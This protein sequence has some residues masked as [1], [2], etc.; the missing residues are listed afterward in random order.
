MSSPL[1]ANDLPSFKDR[2]VSV[3]VVN[4]NGMR[5]LENC[6]DS[7][8]SAFTRYSLELIVVDNASSD[9]SQA[10]LRARTDIVYV[11]SK[12]NSGFTGGNNLGANYAKGDVLLFINNDTQVQ[13]SL[14]EVIDLLADSHTGIS[15][16]RLL[17]GD[18]RQQF[19]FGYEHTPIRIFCS[20]LGLEKLY[21]LPTIFRKLET[22]PDAYLCSQNY[23]N[24]VSGACFAI[25]RVDWNAVNGFD[26]S[27]F[28]YCEDV[29]LCKR[30][31]DLGL[32]IA[33]TPASTVVHYEGSGKAWI[34][35][36]ALQR[37]VK[38]YQLFTL[39]HYGYTTAM[40][41]SLALAFVFATRALAFGI[42][43]FIRAD[44]KQLNKEKA[45]GFWRAGVQLV[46]SLTPSTIKSARP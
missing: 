5:F 8:K 34:G 24:W 38:S 29:D 36:T 27:Y 32:T 11:E 39:K 33:Y 20:W 15:A 45:S 35:Q 42:F 21:T 25:R 4:F 7:V 18:G 30:V 10:L 13:T 16:C 17:Y 12:V 44:A 37:T 28:M 14:D 2:L 19:S 40:V 3:I 22:S 1:N 26:T 9:G 31:R 41:L 6:L 43:A 23:L 46:Q